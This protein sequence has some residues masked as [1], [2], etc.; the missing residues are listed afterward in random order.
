MAFTA[1]QKDKAV[2]H[3]GFTVT[4]WSINF[5]GSK[6]DEVSSL[7]PEAETR[8]ITI[9]DRMDAVEEQINTHLSW[10]GV[11]VK[12]NGVRY[13]QG[14]AFPEM[15]QQYKYWQAKLAAALGLTLPKVLF[16]SEQLI[17]S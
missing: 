17:R 9:L 7:S 2:G 6:M 4:A 15:Q 13:Y 1:A 16:K 3:L 12:P 14:Q 8:V 5:I 11:Q 10:S